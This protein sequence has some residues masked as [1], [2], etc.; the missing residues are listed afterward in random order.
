[1]ASAYWAVPIK[2][3]D[4]YK[5]AFM[6]PR[7][8]YEMCVTVFGLCSSQPTYQ[9]IMD[10]TLD[11]VKNA[12]SFVDDVNTYND[13]FQNMLITLCELLERFRKAKLQMRTDKCK[14]G[15]SEIDFVGYHISSTVMSP[16]IENI[17]AILDYEAP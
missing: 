9:R 5:T 10:N 6:I 15:Y 7:G 12:D 1:M 8:L 17:D 13:S 4:R 16:I 11:G 3:E 14:F 2:E